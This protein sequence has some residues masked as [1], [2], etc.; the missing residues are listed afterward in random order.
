MGHDSDCDWDGILIYSS[1]HIGWFRIRAYIHHEKSRLLYL[2]KLNLINNSVNLFKPPQR[3]GLATVPRSQPHSPWCGAPSIGCIAAIIPSPTLTNWLHDQGLI[4]YIIQRHTIEYNWN[5][6]SFS[7]S[8]SGWKISWRLASSS[9]AVGRSNGSVDQQT[10]NISH[11]LFHSSR[12]RSPIRVG[13][14]ERS[15]ALLFSP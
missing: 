13:G 8:G 9:D 12:I 6:D 15:S 7:A 5:H 4:A 10:F 1:I 2:L 11:N 3:L 14:F